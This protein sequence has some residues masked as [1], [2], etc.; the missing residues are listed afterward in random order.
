MLLVGYLL[1]LIISFYLLAEVSDRY[2]VVSLDKISHR[3]KMTHDMAGATLM[4]IGS[5]APEL[6]V[7]IIALVRPGDHEN[8]GIGTIV[9]SALFN[10]LV[11]VGAAAIVKNSL[12]AWQPI[13]R[14]LLFYA[15]AILGLYY[16]L[17]NGK[18]ETWE[19]LLLVIL[20]G[21]YIYAVIKW[22]KWFNFKQLDEDPEEEED[23]E[24]KGWKTVFKP[25]D[26]LLSKFFPST[27]HYMWSFGI[28][29][30]LIAALCWVLVESAIGVSR[31]LDVP[32]VVIALTVLAVGTSVPDMISSVIVAKQGR[33][34]MAVS[35]AIGS[36]I[37]DIFVGLGLPW[38]IKTLVSGKAIRF[39]IVGLDIS[40]GLLFGSVL[41]ILFFLMWKKWKLTQNLGIFLILL[42]IIYVI[43][44][45]FRVYVSYDALMEII[46]NIF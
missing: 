1:A 32:E 5:S 15:I 27:E 13:I 33:A 35:N 37:F 6:F 43:W 3:L 11:I 36:N 30:L 26:W 10:L 9:G 46:Q 14:D 7:S 20:Y 38:L 12:I 21:G 29:I 39:D 17:N 41:L 25:F 22:K 28:S 23:E 42:Y 16:V 31:I 40:V 45:I 8:I 2:F 44:E 34:G 18:V 19:G 24:K 4:A